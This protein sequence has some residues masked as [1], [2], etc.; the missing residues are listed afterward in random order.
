MEKYSDQIKM[1]WSTLLESKRGRA[2]NKHTAKAWF[3]LVEEVTT[4]YSIVLDTTYGVDKVGTNPFNGIKRWAMG[5]RRAA[6]QY[7]QQDG[8]GENITVL[9]TICTDGTTFYSHLQE[10]MLPDKVKVR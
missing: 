5:A 4:K 10:R 2:V 6:S 9:M 3:D 8:N 1:S 7:Q